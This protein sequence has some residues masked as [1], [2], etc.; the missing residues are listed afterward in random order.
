MK[1]TIYS[2][3]AFVFLIAVILF[4]ANYFL[5]TKNDLKISTNS[6]E[7]EVKNFYNLP[8]SKILSKN[9][10]TTLAD[11]TYYN[12][13]YNPQGSYFI[14]L[15][16]DKNLKTSRE[17]AEADLL[18]LLNINKEDACKLNI[19]VGVPFSVSEDYA[20]INLGLSFCNGSIEL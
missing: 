1:K 10:D 3:I 18:K 4:F 16:Y 20:G 14:I 8:T 11:N 15:L 7:M 17:K 19:R 6:G 13:Y 5:K 9:N 12:I 2:L